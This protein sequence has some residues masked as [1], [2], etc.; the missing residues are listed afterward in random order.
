MAVEPVPGSVSTPGN[1][2]ITY[3][4]GST[5]NPLSVAALTGSGAK[6]LT[7]S[8]TGSGFTRGITQD[9]IDDP[10]LTLATKLSR[11]GVA[12]ETLE[13]QYVYNPTVAQ[14]AATAQ[15]VLTEGTSGYLVVRYGV[16][17]ANAYAVGDKVTVISFQAGKQRKDAPADNGVYTIT[18][19]QF[20][21]GVSQEDQALVA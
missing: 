10:R 16:P 1:L 20:I 3:L 15:S 8:F 14:S 5:A 6:D 19:T 11:P 13:T 21:T 9:S 2:K 4:P 17:N 7:Y 18:Q 12:T